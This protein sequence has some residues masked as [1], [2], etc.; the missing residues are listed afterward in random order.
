MENHRTAMNKYK[1]KTTNKPL[2]LRR[3]S[4]VQDGTG[5]P[6]AGKEGSTQGMMGT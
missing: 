2:Y 5:K 6:W 4:K 1:I 3:T